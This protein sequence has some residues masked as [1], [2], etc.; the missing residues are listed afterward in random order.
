MFD[1]INLELAHKDTFFFSYRKNMPTFFGN[2]LIKYVKL[3]L[4]N[5]KVVT[6]FEIN[7][8]Q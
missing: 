2:C 4:C 5:I 3:G 6:L 7:K 1:L 8:F